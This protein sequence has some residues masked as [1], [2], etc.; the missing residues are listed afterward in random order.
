MINR[1]SRADEMLSSRVKRRVSRVIDAR[2][3]LPFGM[4][5][6]D[7]VCEDLYKQYDAVLGIGRTR[8]LALEHL[9]TEM[10][11]AG[12]DRAIIHAEFEC[13]DPADAL[14]EAVAQTVAAYP[15]T[16][17]G[18]GT[19]SVGSRNPARMMRQVRR[20]VELGLIGVGLQP[21]FFGLP[22][23]DRVLYPMYAQAA[24]LGLPVAIHTGVNYS[25]RAPISNE[26]PLQLDQV[27][28]DFP[29]LVLIATHA[30]WPWVADLVAVA[31]RHP[32]I[33]IDFGG[34]A[35]KYL[36]A[37]GAGW[38]VLYHFMNSVLSDRILFATDWPVMTI[39][40]AL[41]EWLEL[42][43]K[44]TT[45]EAALGGNIVRVLGLREKKHE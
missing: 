6:A 33:Y 25:R 40:R 3:R 27:A 34:L 29:E 8:H 20:I 41:G 44:P 28:C 36:G 14:N 30:S 45:L 31:R 42:G 39:Q 38:E 1:A 16:F 24:E 43:L 9:L 2:V 11:E 22:I 37:A 17:S 35:P 10:Q 13:G 15:D 18:F 23:N 12:V 21:A 19:V 5:P 26:H 4:Y 32:T 7:S